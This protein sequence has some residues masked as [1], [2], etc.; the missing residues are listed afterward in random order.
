MNY[1]IL[2]FILVLLFTFSIALLIYKKGK[3]IGN[4]PKDMQEYLD[5]KSKIIRG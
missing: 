4:D 2:P 5:I 1:F 3:R